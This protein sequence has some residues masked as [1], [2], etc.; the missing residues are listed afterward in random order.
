MRPMEQNRF[1]RWEIIEG[2]G[3][4]VTARCDCGTVK[5]VR[6]R[7]LRCGESKSCGCDKAL[8]GKRISE[9]KMRH[10]ATRTPAWVAWVGMRTRCNNP[11]LPSYQWWGGRGIRVCERWSSF[12]NFLADMGQPPAPRMSLDRIDNDGDYEPGNCRWADHRTQ[13]HNRRDNRVLETPRGPMLMIDAAKAYGLGVSTL[14][15]RLRHGWD[16]LDAL[17]TP[18]YGR[19]VRRAA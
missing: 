9:A 6:R 18:K 15:W 13:A 17:T 2:D 11:N 10:G 7:S 3:A 14:S 4:L 12:E 5:I 19:W 8:R 16:V 1:G